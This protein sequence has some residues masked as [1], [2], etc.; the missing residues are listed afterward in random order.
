MTIWGESELYPGIRSMFKKLTW[1]QND[2]IAGCCHDGINV[3]LYAGMVATAPKDQWEKM[4][5]DQDTNPLRW[6]NF[7]EAILPP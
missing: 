2:L 5:V 1:R 4:L 7:T 3:G 6:T